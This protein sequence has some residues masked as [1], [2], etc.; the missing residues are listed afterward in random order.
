MRGIPSRRDGLLGEDSFER[1]VTS[2]SARLLRVAFL[3]A[4]DHTEAE[5]LLQAAL[6]RLLR[7]WPQISERPEA[8]A[9]KVLVNLSHDRHRRLSRRPREVPQHHA[10]ELELE[11]EREV[12]RFVERDAVT[13][14][15]RFLPRRQ[16][17]VVALRF[18]LDLSVA[19][20][21]SALRCSEGAVKGYT[22]RALASMR[23]LLEERSTTPIDDRFGGMHAQ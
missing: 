8:Y 16:R 2:E 11:A 5:D 1:F 13:Q 17:E 23:K 14:V 7:R 6:V 21:A 18:F 10:L 12:D 9:L 15:V 22:A 4:G 20:T 19:E 3:L